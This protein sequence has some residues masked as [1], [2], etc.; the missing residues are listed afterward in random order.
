MEHAVKVASRI[1]SKSFGS[2]QKVNIVSLRLPQTP[3]SVDPRRWPSSVDALQKIRKENQREPTSRHSYINILGKLE[4][5]TWPVTDKTLTE[6][7][8]PVMQLDALLIMVA[9]NKGISNTTYPQI[10]GQTR[11]ISWLM[12]RVARDVHSSCDD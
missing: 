6:A 8:D 4:D 2:C 11:P 12:L 1:V 10:L 7:I 5:A 3:R 9:G